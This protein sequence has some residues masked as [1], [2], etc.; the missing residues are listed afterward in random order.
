MAGFIV[1]VGA[2]RRLGLL[3]YLGFEFCIYLARVHT[4]VVGQASTLAEYQIAVKT[5][6][7]GV[8]TSDMLIPL[9]P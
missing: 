9:C 8:H 1:N 5:H 4:E 7:L 2:A 3:V 6:V